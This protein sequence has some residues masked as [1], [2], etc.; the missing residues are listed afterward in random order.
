MPGFTLQWILS[1]GISSMS[2]ELPFPQKTRAQWPSTGESPTFATKQPAAATRASLGTWH[3]PGSPVSP[4]PSG[5]AHFPACHFP[6]ESRQALLGEA[7]APLVPPVPWEGLRGGD[8]LE[9]SGTRSPSLIPLP[10]IAREPVAWMSPEAPPLEDAPGPVPF[11]PPAVLASW[12]VRAPAGANP[13]PGVPGAASWGP[14][15]SPLVG[16]YAGTPPTRTVP[17]PDFLFGESRP[18]LYLRPST[19]ERSSSSR[20][21]NGVWSDSSSLETDSASLAPEGWEVRRPPPRRRSR[22]VL[23]RE[24]VRPADPGGGSAPPVPGPSSDGGAAPLWK[25]ATAPPETTQPARKARRV[26]FR[27]EGVFRGRGFWAIGLGRGES[28][29]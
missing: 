10:P 7:S 16:R 20:L 4:V 23:L 3:R 24:W 14:G 22:K 26:L 1:S 28:L 29:P 18:S 2:Q 6:P 25:R 5:Q 9:A 12:A 11:L 17:K 19:A 15:T 27:R 13:V 21:A 8:P